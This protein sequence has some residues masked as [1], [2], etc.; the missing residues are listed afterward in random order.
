MTINR[1]KRNHN[2]MCRAF[3]IGCLSIQLS[4]CAAWFK[5]DPSE[6]S[7]DQH[8]ENPYQYLEAYLSNPPEQAILESEPLKSHVNGL[9]K[10]QREFFNTSREQVKPLTQIMQGYL[11]S[12]GH[13]IA[14]DKRSLVIIDIERIAL[15]VVLVDTE[16]SKIKVLQ[17]INQE[18]TDDV[19]QEM[20]EYAENWAFGQLGKAK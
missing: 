20:E 6:K 2:F 16:T 7:A 3:I 17:R 11:L 1:S 18:L 10:D 5:S 19:I 4:S 12:E 15:M 13:N 9:L 8:V 14:D